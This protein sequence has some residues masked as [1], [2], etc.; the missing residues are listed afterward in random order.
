M[1]QATLAKEIPSILKKIHKNS[2]KIVIFYCQNHI[3]YA[4]DKHN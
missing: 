3:I 1:K 2:R 4:M